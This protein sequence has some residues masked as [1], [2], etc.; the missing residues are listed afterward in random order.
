M[1]RTTFLVVLA[2]LVAAP[3]LAGGIHPRVI[4]QAMVI[5]GADASDPTA[6]GFPRAKA[7]VT[8]FLA[9]TADQVASWE[10][11]IATREDAVGPLR[12]QLKSTED[13][14]KELLNGDD[15]DPNAVGTLVISGKT[16]RD[17]IQAARQTYLEG[18]E[19][20]LTQDQKVKLG[21]V[22]RAARLAPLVPAFGVVGLLVPA[23]Q[24]EPAQ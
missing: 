21:A 15:P 22:R 10:T 20:M 14:L 2:G 8:Q 23:P 5:A 1:K 9:L 11:L 13:E 12:D 4:E 18:F 16:L 19:A 17:G 6:L 7:A 3:L 24:P